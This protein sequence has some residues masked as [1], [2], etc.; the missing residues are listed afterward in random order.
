M[1]IATHRV[2]TLD[3]KQNN[4]NI[5]TTKEKHCE[6]NKRNEIHTRKSLDP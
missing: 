6:E 4:K 2:C 5:E 3:K 1:E